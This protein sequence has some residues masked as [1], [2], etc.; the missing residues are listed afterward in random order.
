MRSSYCVIQAATHSLF[1]FPAASIMASSETKN[2]TNI[3]HST[4]KRRRSAN[5]TSSISKP[6]SQSPDSIDITH[7]EMAGLAAIVDIDTTAFMNH[8]MP[9]FEATYSAL[10]KQPTIIKR[11]HRHF[12]EVPNKLESDMYSPLVR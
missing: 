10:H 11:V 5:Y 9:D 7:Q 8:L 6:S 2:E 4:P 12:L 3:V 1:P